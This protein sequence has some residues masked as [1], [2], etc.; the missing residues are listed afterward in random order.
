MTSLTIFDTL[1]RVCGSFLVWI[2]K[3]DFF[4]KYGVFA[5]YSPF[6]L[7]EK[8]SHILLHLQITV[9]AATCKFIV[10]ICQFNTHYI[11]DTLITPSSRTSPRSTEIATSFTTLQYEHLPTGSCHSSLRETLRRCVIR[12]CGHYCVFSEVNVSICVAFWAT[13]LAILD[14]TI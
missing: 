9:F 3:I 10:V 14:L 6:C 4:S 13:L 5:I 11:V 2:A 1:E 7:S 12:F 8:M